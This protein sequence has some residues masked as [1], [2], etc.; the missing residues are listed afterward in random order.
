LSEPRKSFDSTTDGNLIS[1]YENSSEEE[2]QDTLGKEK[3][4]KVQN[5]LSSVKRY[6]IMVN[7]VYSLNSVITSLRI[8][9]A[10]ETKIQIQ[11]GY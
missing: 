7:K 9:T 10:K 3:I 2:K 6:Q 5:K 8:R 11:I 1:T 4:K